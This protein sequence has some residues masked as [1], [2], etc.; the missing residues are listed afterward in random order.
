MNCTVN[1]VGDEIRVE[2]P[3]ELITVACD[4]WQERGGAVTA[5]ALVQT[6]APGI[7]PHVHQARLTLTSTRTRKEFA[8]E[9]AGRF[10]GPE[11]DRLIEHVA[12]VCLKV[13]RAGAPA[14]LL[15]AVDPGVRPKYRVEGIVPESGVTVLYGPGGVG[16]STVALVMACAVQ[17]ARPFASRATMGGQVLYLDYETS[18][19]QQSRRLRAIARGMELLATPPILY[20]R[21]DVPLTECAPDLR[22]LCADSDIGFVVLDSLAY[23]GGGQADA[24]PT[25]VVFRA[26]NSLRIPVL[27]LAHVSKH[28]N[29][30]EPYGSVFVRNS[31]RSMLEVRKYQEAADDQLDLG[32]FHRKINDDRLQRPFGLR[33]HFLQDATLVQPLDI[34]AIPG[35][36]RDLSLGERVLA[37]I[38]EQARTE[39]DL[40]EFL[41]AKAESVARVLRRLRGRSKVL[42]LEDGRW[43]LLTDSPRTG[44]DS[45]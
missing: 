7:P 23:A 26:L 20:K 4:R 42:R 9:C 13:R 10:S 14:T 15:S 2:F 24:E 6:T 11:W 45:P 36:E 33:V 22:R 35:M 17:E 34:R 37:A 30:A 32:I 16:K 27:A 21:V 39:Q 3:D 38:R 1:V 25:L 29:S 31:A 28:G 41:E 12:I 19:H 40:A 5:E 43:G 18:E 8:K 44:A